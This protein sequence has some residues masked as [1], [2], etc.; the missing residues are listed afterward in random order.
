MQV[1]S[2]YR[3][4]LEGPEASILS[5]TDGETIIPFISSKDHKQIYDGGLGPN[6]GGWE[7]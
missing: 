4:I 1:K 2:C 6:T 7:L 5:I 3:R